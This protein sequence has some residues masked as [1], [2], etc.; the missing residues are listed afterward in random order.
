MRIFGWIFILTLFASSC[1]KELLVPLPEPTPK[2]VIESY[3]RVFKFNS[4]NKMLFELRKSSGTN[5]TTTYGIVNDAVVLL[6]KNNVFF[7]TLKIDTSGEFYN[8]NFTLANAPR[9][10]DLFKVEIIHPDFP[11][12]YAST[13]ILDAIF[14]TDTVITP[15]YSLSSSTG[16]K[17]KVDIT[18]QDPPEDNYYEIVV[19]DLSMVGER[20]VYTTFSSVV[21]ESY[22]PKPYDLLNGSQPTSLLFSDKDFKDQK[23][24]IDVI[25]PIFGEIFDGEYVQKISLRHI[26]KEQYDFKTSVLEHLKS[27]QS[28]ILYGVSEPLTLKSYVTNGYGIFAGY[29]ETIIDITYKL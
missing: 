2:L 15:I 22:Y 11:L 27:K 12:T 19:T 18:F 25:Y 7:D 23:V 13:K 10:G 16:N 26:T 21:N 1:E 3:L 5:D 24:T 17:T 29:N 9:T 20:S 8:Y 6:Y 14:I 4:N 28:D